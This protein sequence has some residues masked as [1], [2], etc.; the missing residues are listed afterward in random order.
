MSVLKKHIFICE[1]MRDPDSPKGCCGRKGGSELKVSFKKK[2]ALKLLNKIYRANTAGCMDACE[3]GAVVVIYPQ[4]IWY[5]GV[6]MNDVDEIIEE[7]VL[8]DKVISRLVIKE[9]MDEKSTAS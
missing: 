4:G 6:T 7:T 2:L 5:G 3:H 1:N 8:N 9:K